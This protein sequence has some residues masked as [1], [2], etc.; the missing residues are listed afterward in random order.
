M[1]WRAWAIA[2]A[3]VVM[4][5]SAN[6][7]AAATTRLYTV[8]AS[9]FQNSFGLPVPIDPVQISFRLTLDPTFRTF[10]TET[11]IGLVSSNVPIDG[12]LGFEY[13]DPS[14]GDLLSVGGSVSGLYALLGGT[15]DIYIDLRNVAGG[16]PTLNLLLYRQTGPGAGFRSFTGSVSVAEVPEPSAWAL[17]LVGFGFAGAAMRRRRPQNV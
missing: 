6:A 11:G 1:M 4:G 13:L 7:Y 9:D 16:H 14:L 10:E 15:Q 17:M 12:G 8:T 3:A 2:T 5:W